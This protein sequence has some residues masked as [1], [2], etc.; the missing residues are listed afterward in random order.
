MSYL[1]RDVNVE[2]IHVVVEYETFYIEGLDD[3]EIAIKSIKLKGSDVDISILLS[4]YIDMY[5]REY[6]RK[7]HW[8]EKE[9]EHITTN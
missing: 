5:M 4:E 7:E 1:K 2:G 9:N 8:K 6:L 3:Y